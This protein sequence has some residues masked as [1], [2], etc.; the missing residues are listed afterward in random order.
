M[1][2]QNTEKNIGMIDVGAKQVTRREARATARVLIGAELVTKVKDNAIPKGNILE[3]A[4]VAGIMAA[5]NT[6]SNI[7]LC[8]PLPLE[9]AA[10][11]FE[12]LEDQVVITTTVCATAKTGVEMEALSAAAAAAL[13]IYDMCKMFSKGIVIQ[14]LMLLQKS[15]GKS[16]DYQRKN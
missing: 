7:P 12:L 5:K 13:S 10:V 1:E 16:G 6:G 4:R 3:F 2:Q 15:G 8:H 14:D 9:K 11:D